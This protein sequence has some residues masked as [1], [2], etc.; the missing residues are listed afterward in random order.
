MPGAK[1]FEDLLIWQRARVLANLTYKLT[2][3]SSFRDSDLR[4]QMPGQLSP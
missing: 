3:E 2:A 1:R 4:S